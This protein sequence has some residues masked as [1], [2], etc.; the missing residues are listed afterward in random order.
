MN[1]DLINK[2]SDIEWSISFAGFVSK[3]INDY[4]AFWK[5]EFS[6]KRAPEVT[7]CIKLD[8]ELHVK[9]LSKGCPVPLPQ[10]LRQGIDCRLTIKGMLENFP[11]YLKTYTDNNSS[12]FEEL[13]QCRFTK[14]SI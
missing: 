5:T 3:K 9:L 7:E 8:K 2:L 4:V 6:K 12:I 1:Y 10:W 14:K 11:V 13:L